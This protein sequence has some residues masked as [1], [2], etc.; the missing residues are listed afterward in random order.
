IDG[1]TCPDSY[2]GDGDC[3]CGCGAPDPDCAGAGLTVGGESTSPG[4]C[5]SGVG[6]GDISPANPAVCVG[7]V[8]NC[9]DGVAGVGEICDGADLRGFACTDF[10]TFVGGTLGCADGCDAFDFETCEGPEI[11]E[12]WTCDEAWVG[13][14]DCDCGCGAQDPDCSGTSD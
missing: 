10:G 13:D 9:G 8:V 3:D 12:G 11:P 7:T 5:A 2:F 14:G 4:S 6:C 1:W